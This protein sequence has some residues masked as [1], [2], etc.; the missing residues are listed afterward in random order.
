MKSWVIWERGAATPSRRFMGTASGLRDIRSTGGTAYPSRDNYEDVP[1]GVR[2]A[3]YGGPIFAALGVGGGAVLALPLVDGTLS[4]IHLAGGFA[5]FVGSFTGLI[6][7]YLLLVMV[8]LAARIPALENSVGRLKVMRWHKNLA[9]WPIALIVI[10]V[11]STTWGY[12]ISAHRGYFHEFGD[13]V[14]KFPGMITATVAFGIIVVVGISS[15]YAVRRHIAHENW[16]LLHLL[17]YVSIVLAFA[18]ELAVGP[19]FVAHPLVRWLW[20]G[21]WSLVGACVLVFRV[22]LPWWRSRRYRLRVHRVIHEVGGVTSLELTGKGLDR[23]K[24]LGGQFCEWRFLTPRLFWQAHPLT[25]SARGDDFLRLTVANR[26]DFSGSLARL[27]VG[28]RVSFEGPY[29]VFTARVRERRLVALI[30]G[31]IGITAVRGL[32]PELGQDTRPTVILRVRSESDTPLVN[33]V[34]DLVASRDGV[35]HVVEG[36]REDVALA[37]LVTLI[38][39]IARRDIFVSGS[40]EFVAAMSVALRDAGVSQEVIH[41][42]AYAL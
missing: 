3:T 37:D 11:L 29:G 30:A 39:E 32:L 34:R 13:L 24:I 21:A 7:T 8:V 14:E 5:L 12:A 15:Y 18:H 36:R 40:A 9:P 31:G 26:G 19:S 10:H 42:E 23:L 22:G 25:V 38:G 28:T 1:R 27:A 20:L 17:L 33:E 2:R 41:H 6:G 35:L 4:E 16:W